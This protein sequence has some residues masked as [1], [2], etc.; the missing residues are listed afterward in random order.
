[1]LTFFRSLKPWQ[2]WLLIAAMLQALFVIIASLESPVFDKHTFRQSQV[3]LTIYWLAQGGPWLAY[4]TPVLGYP[5]SIPMEFPVY[6]LMV[7]GISWLTVPSIDV[8]GRLVGFFFYLGVL[9]V[10]VRLA[11]HFEVDSQKVFFFC[12]F[13]LVSPFFLFWGR[14]VMIESTAVFFSL[15]WLFAL[16]KALEGDSD[17]IANKILWFLF[18][19]LA[20]VLGAL[21]KVT[22]FFVF[23]IAGGIYVLLYLYQRQLLTTTRSLLPL[24]ASL[25]IV[26][27]PLLAIVLFTGY[28][29][30]L[31]RTHPVASFLT[32]DSMAAWNYGTLEQRLDVSNWGELTYRLLKKLI[33]PGSL[34]LLVC[35]VFLRWTRREL[36]LA[37][38]L[39]FV[40]I[41]PFLVFFNLHVHHDYYQ[42]ANYIFALVLFSWIM[43][44]VYEQFSGNKPRNILISV[45]VLAI[46]QFYASYF[47][48]MN[49]PGSIEVENYVEQQTKPSQAIMVFGFDW[50]SEVAYYSERKSLTFPA[51]VDENK[52]REILDNPT[53]YLGG[54]PLGAIVVL[55]GKVPKQHDRALTDYFARV[56]STKRCFGDHCVYTKF[57]S[58]TDQ[59]I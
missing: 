55:K 50:S 32:S 38:I 46:A 23:G 29:D 57:R 19:I 13:Y 43:A 15:V 44:K 37:G 5:W 52:T 7:A 56:S 10:A 59:G 25:V 35:A 9:P 18:A 45:M 36:F 53:T 30:D 49:N 17:I 8:A 11:R 33:G 22:T 34:V 48:K 41:S 42:Y 28:A 4:E 58:N 51:M 3:G 24:G 21:T 54:M 2:Q 39:L 31:K 40:Y 20:G 14:T 1:M 16:I 6:Q 26:S 27:V 47:S 12:L